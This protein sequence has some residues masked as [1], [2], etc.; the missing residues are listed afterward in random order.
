[1]ARPTTGGGDGVGLA[2][3]SDGTLWAWRSNLSGELGDGT[4]TG[5]DVCA[6]PPSYPQVCR[7]TPEQVGTAT[8]WVVVS[9]AG[10]AVAALRS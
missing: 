10:G 8:N 4:G 7:A 3:R 1:V 5:P 9:A 6:V 2:V